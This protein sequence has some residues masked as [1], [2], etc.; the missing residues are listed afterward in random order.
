MLYLVAAVV[1][2]RPDLRAPAAWLLGVIS[3]LVLIRLTARDVV[4]IG[5]TAAD[6]I[7]AAKGG[8]GK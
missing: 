5:K 2:A 8:E 3:G 1:I 4:G 6:V 7:R